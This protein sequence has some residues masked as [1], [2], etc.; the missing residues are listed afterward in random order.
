MSK[1]HEWQTIVKLAEDKDFL[2]RKVELIQ[3]GIGIEGKFR[4]PP[5]AKLSMEDQVFIA[6]FIKT[7]GSIKEM[8]RL[9]GV[10]YPTIKSRLI[11]L[12]EALTFV[13]IEKLTQERSVVDRVGDGEISVQEALLELDGKK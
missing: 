11:K 6:V 2:V 13:D 3:D 9:Y 10:S 1:I 5:L 4:L 7:H 8:E 12:G